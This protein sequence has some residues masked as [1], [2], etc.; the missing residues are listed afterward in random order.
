MIDDRT[1]GDLRMAATLVHALPGIVLRVDGARASHRVGHGLVATD[2]DTLTP[3][4]FR[5][6]V[7]QAHHLRERGRP[8][9]LIGLCPAERPTLTLSAEAGHDVLP[10]GICLVRD[11]EGWRVVT[12][13][14]LAQEVCREVLLVAGDEPEDQVPLALHRDDAT[15]VTLVHTC[16]DDDHLDLAV[17]AIEAALARCATAELLGDYSGIGSAQP[18]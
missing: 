11:E 17:N 4:G 15:G 8:I 18:P 1:M 10:G 14:L 3:C 7:V 5:V 6:A 9:S 13:T 16:S 12:A 2:D